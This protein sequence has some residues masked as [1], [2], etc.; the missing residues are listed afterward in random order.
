[1]MKFQYIT[2]LGGTTF[3]L[4]TGFIFLCCRAYKTK[5]KSGAIIFVFFGMLIG[6]LSGF[7]ILFNLDTMK[8]WNPY[9]WWLLATFLTT[10]FGGFLGLIVFGLLTNKKSEK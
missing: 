9:G 10:V 3:L 7:L 2:I 1:M 8:G 4:I 6:C 5:I